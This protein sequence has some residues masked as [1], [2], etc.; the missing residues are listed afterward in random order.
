MMFTRFETYKVVLIHYL[1]QESTYLKR[2]PSTIGVR[3][4]VMH[5]LA[6]S[7]YEMQGVR[8]QMQQPIFDHGYYWPSASINDMAPAH[9]CKHC[10]QVQPQ[11]VAW[12]QKKD[13]FHTAVKIREGCW[14]P[15]SYVCCYVPSFGPCTVQ[16]LF[17]FSSSILL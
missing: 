10:C 4:I 15:F 12:P 5:S 2:Y 11:A 8:F 3:N 1:I 6:P 17:A 16:G 13:T 7:L 9:N 14:L